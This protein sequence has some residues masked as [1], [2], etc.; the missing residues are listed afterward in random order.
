MSN[1]MKTTRTALLTLLVA[2]ISLSVS[3][4]NVTVKGTVK[5]KTGETV[6]GASVVEK[7]NTSNGTITD[8]D[9]NYTLS[10]PSN[11]T[12]VFSYVGM[13]TQEVSVKGKTT[14]DIVMEDDAQALEEVVVIGYG[15]VKRKDLTGSVATVSSDVLAAVPVASA[16]EALTGKMAGVQITTTEGSP[17]AEMKI[18]VRGGGSITGDN[19]PLF[20]VDGFPVESISDIP[21]SDIEDITVLKD[22]SSTAIYGSRGANGVILVTT[23]S[24]KEGKI[25][26]SYNAYYSWKK[27]AKTLD[28][29]DPYDYAKWQ[30]EQ[31]LLRGNSYVED[32]ESY[33]GSYEDLDMYKNIPYNDWQDLTFGRTGNTFNHNLSITGGSEKIK[34]AFSYS[35]MNDKA[36]MEGSDYKRDNFSLKLNTKPVK[37]V[38]LD[39]SIRYSETNIGGGGANDVSSTYDSDKRLKYSVIYTPIPLENMDSSAGSSDDDLGNLYHPLTAISDNDRDQERKTLNMSGS[40]GWEIFKN[41]KFKTE[42][43]YDDYRNDDLRFYG[44][45]TYYVKNVPSAEN[46]NLPAIQ[47]ANTNR[48]KFRNTNT[49][50]YDFSDLFKGDSHHL[51]AMIGHEW[52][53]TK[54]SK[55]TNIVHGFPET[56]TAADAWKLTSMGT[57]FSIDNFYDP[58]D[59]LLSYFGRINYDYQSKYLLSA[60]FRADGSSKFA[61]GNQWGYFPSAAVAWRVSSENFMEGTKEWLDDLKLRFSYGTAGNNNIPSGQMVQTYSNSATSWINGFSNYWAPSKTMANPDLKWETTIT[62]NLGLD[63]TVLG[64]KLNGTIE[65]YLNTTTDLLIQ[66]PVGGTGYDT[67]YRNM[68]KTENKGI[69]AS[70]NWTIVNKKDWGVS[71]NANIGFNK[72]T[73]KDLGMM[74]DFGAETYWA[75]SEIGNDFWIAK[76]GSVG[77]MYGY[78]SDG[79]YEASDF[80]G[81]D[82]AT[83]SW[84]LKE[85]VVDASAVVGKIRPGSMKLK[86]IDGSE[87]NKVT[88]DDREIIGDANPLHTG[89]FG[90]SAY[91]YGFDL[92]ANFNWSFGNDVYNANKIEFTQTG[93][94]Q[95][96]NMTS[97]MADGKRWTNLRADGTLSTDLEELAAMNANTTMW[98]PL[99]DRMIFSDWAVE[100]GSFL[101]LN[102]LTLGY[103]LPKSLLSKVKIQNLRFYVTG[104]NLFCLTSYTGY[105]PEVSTIR[106]TNLTPGVDY[107]AYPKSR[108]FVVGVN[109]N[110]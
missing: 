94:Y 3:A 55:L 43:G 58:D 83:D 45:T 73:I 21:A 76:G 69:E 7:G 52:I 40:F 64:G 54:S 13:T 31:A 12:I 51:N 85:G 63:F 89:G 6:I 50:S 92:S 56:F 71:F 46:Q 8:I 68:G 81:Y 105:D 96:R 16:T 88:T 66:F 1:K 87:D 32:Y 90:I 100:D 41:F 72:N 67:Q 57:P 60:T 61:A 24:G 29:L 86:N 5:D 62:R 15:S 48:H 98:S 10:V 19:T 82:A 33:F 84:I 97:E 20:I 77:Q 27:I 65:A 44:L 74:N 26:V 11:A 93:K 17:D 110:F 42:L 18:R 28:V 34:Y 4:Q 99:T 75:S 35:H 80:V 91:A 108:Q 25:N 22:A 36:I 53:I 37:N 39:F 101:R 14:I 109:L 30:Y 47:I 103:T 79:R 104:Y 2:L 9:G 107:S 78:R 70:I 95:Y 49:I 106:K 38:T 23:K 59:K 102:T